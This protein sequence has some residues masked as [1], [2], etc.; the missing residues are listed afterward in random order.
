MVCHLCLFPLV[1]DDRIHLPEG[2][3]R[4]AVCIAEDGQDCE[5][6]R[7][8]EEHARNSL[9]VDHDGEDDPSHP[10]M[11]DLVVLPCYASLELVDTE[12][13]KSVLAHHP[14]LKSFLC[15]LPH[16]NLTEVDDI[17]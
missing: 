11:L 4:D 12:D 1:E 9:E 7:Q 15:L 3:V 6:N 17:Q 2:N 14:F 10:S 13:E 16:S 8:E 5:K